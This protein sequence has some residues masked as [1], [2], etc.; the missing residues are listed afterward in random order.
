MTTANVHGPAA[1]A[2]PSDFDYVKV[3]LILAVIT[4]AEITIPYQMDVKGPVIGLLLVLMLS[5]FSIVAMWFMHL[6][7][8]SRLFRMVFIAGLLL[9]TMVYL[10]VMTSFQLF[11][12]DTTSQPL[13]QLPAPAR[14]RF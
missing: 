11:G 6:R 13:D 8:D 9:A 7:F 4:G 14:I 2:H 12:R 3:A 10:G 1:H 5:K